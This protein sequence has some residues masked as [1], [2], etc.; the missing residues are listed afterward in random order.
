MRGRGWCSRRGD[1][2]DSG[3]CRATPTPQCHVRADGSS[4]LTAHP[5]HTVRPHL[6]THS[7]TLSPP[8]ALPLA[9]GYDHRQGVL[10]ARVLILPEDR[11]PPMPSVL[12][13]TGP[14]RRLATRSDKCV[15]RVAT[16]Q[17]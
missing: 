8:P 1:G 10:W 2:T 15:R 3:F 7:L 5:I 17:T 11:V 13:L 9:P 4:Y 16:A 14:M 12:P 6:L